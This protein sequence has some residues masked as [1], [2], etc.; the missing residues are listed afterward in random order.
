MMS[1]K[2]DIPT[3]CKC[4][5][6]SNVKIPESMLYLMWVHTSGSACKQ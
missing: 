3:I 6:E 2:R 1:N 5:Y 4:N